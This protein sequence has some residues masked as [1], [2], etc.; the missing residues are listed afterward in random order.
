MLKYL[1]IQNLIL[2]DDLE[3]EFNN[4]FTVFSGETGAGKSIILD[5]LLLALG[6]RGSNKL[7]KNSTKSATVTATFD[8]ANSTS[9]LFE[10]L[11]AS[12]IEVEDNLLILRRVISAD[13]KSRAF[14]NDVAVNLAFLGKI[15]EHLVEIAGQHDNR[16]LLDPSNHRN[17]LDNFI[18]DVT[19]FDKVNLAFKTF[20]AARDEYETLK[21]KSDNSEFE[22]DFLK[23]VINEIKALNYKESEEEKLETLKKTA[24]EKEK[25]ASLTDSV[26]ALLDQAGFLNKLYSMKKDLARFPDIFNKASESLEKAL[27]E[28]EDFKAYSEEV[29]DSVGGDLNLET[30]EDRLYKIK[31]I[32]RKHGIL[33]ANINEFMQQKIEE[34]DAFEN[35][36]NALIELEKKLKKSEIAYV[37]AAKFLHTL[38]IKNA[39]QLNNLVNQNLKDLKMEKAEFLAEVTFFE[40]AEKWTAKGADLVHFKVR[41]NPNTPLGAIDKIASGGELSRIML[42]IKSAYAKTNSI[43]SIVF[44]EIDTGISG[45]AADSVGKKIAEIS[46]QFQTICVTHQPQVA[47]YSKEHFLVEKFATDTEASVNVRKLTLDEKASEIARMISGESITEE[48]IIAANRLIK[49]AA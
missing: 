7:I 43:A 46:R 44:D 37:E 5:G 22:I 8:T 29:Y 10:I 25:I 45:A 16:G 47:A 11:E 42:A 20:K 35:F 15:R 17:I 40:D 4:G 19:A 41:T 12:E 18:T 21:A 49:S 6:E 31:F 33:P 14:A 24:S 34:L 30:I 9:E 3:L 26:T 39:N 38:R 48:S 2:I 13:G 36:D 27:S 28:L 23:S 1:R 32:S